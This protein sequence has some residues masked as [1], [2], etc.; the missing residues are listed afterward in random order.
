MIYVD[1]KNMVKYDTDK[2]ELVRC[3]TGGLSKRDWNSR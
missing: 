1:T 2:M 3:G